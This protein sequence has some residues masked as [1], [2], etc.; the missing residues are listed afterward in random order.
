ML[1][2]RYH[3]LKFVDLFRKQKRGQIAG[4]IVMGLVMLL[5]LFLYL[6][7]EGYFI[8]LSDPLNIDEVRGRAELCVIQSAENA[9]VNLGK[10]NGYIH[11][12]D[13]ANSISTGNY[14]MN[15]DII[16]DQIKDYLKENVKE[17]LND[18]E[19][20][21]KD[22]NLEFSD[23]SDSEIIYKDD[24]IVIKLFYRIKISDAL[25]KE[26][27]I[28]EDFEAMIPV[29]L[30]SILRLKQQIEQKEKQNKFISNYLTQNLDLPVKQAE[31]S[32]DEYQRVL[33]NFVAVNSKQYLKRIKVL[34]TDYE[35]GDDDVW[36]VTKET[37][38]KVE[39]MFAYNRYPL[40]FNQASFDLKK[41]FNSNL[42][43]YSDYL[44]KDAFDYDFYVN[45]P[46]SVKINDKLSFKEKGYEFNFILPIDLNFA[47]E[48][49]TWK[50]KNF[51]IN[52][53][54]V[55][56]DKDLSSFGNGQ[57]LGSNHHV[58]IQIFGNGFYTAS[59]YP[60]DKVIDLPV[61]DY[62]FN[63]LL[64]K[65]YKLVGGHYTTLSLNDLSKSGVEFDVLLF[66][67]LT[68]SKIVEILQEK[69]YLDGVKFE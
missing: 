65:D 37:F 41:E 57:E 59:L 8:D 55:L 19:D 42:L 44:K 46:I 26:S 25:N 11:E 68:Q 64:F 48:I 35:I 33:M 14:E 29:R 1:K 50:K 15:K 30:D 56:S 43:K 23:D 36:D 62:E 38:P 60:Y 63:A 22:Y 32:L 66:Q 18:F 52:V 47:S 58:L 9:L 10:Q 12:V 20:L 40:K 16:N 49:K 31:Q 4:F 21:K 69:E 61:G 5:F 28:V 27:R 2:K 45:M 54:S 53:K 17:C 34:N 6:Y 13:F 67:G 39:V 7:A 51:N 24:K 3:K